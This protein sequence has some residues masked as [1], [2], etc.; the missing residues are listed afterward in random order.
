VKVAGVGSILCK[1][2]GHYNERKGREW[3]EKCEECGK[4]LGA[5]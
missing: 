4:E 5:K 3:P 1:G 2:C